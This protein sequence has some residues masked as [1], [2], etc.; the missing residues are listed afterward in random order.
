[1]LNK[2]LPSFGCTRQEH[3]E[4][5]LQGFTFRKERIF[6]TSAVVAPKGIVISHTLLSLSSVMD[7]NSIGAEQKVALFPDNEKNPNN[8]KENS[9]QQNQITRV[10]VMDSQENSSNGRKP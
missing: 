10:G 5:L 6:A 1:M 7:C 8:S 2:M 3:V 4:K 9:H